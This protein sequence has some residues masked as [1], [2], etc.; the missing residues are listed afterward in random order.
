MLWGIGRGEHLMLREIEPLVD[1]PVGQN[2]Q[3]HPTAGGSW[4]TS[5]PVSLLVA[6]LPDSM[7]QH[8]EDFMQNG[9]G[10]L[11]SN[12]GESGGFLRTSAVPPAP[13]MQ[14]H[15]RPGVF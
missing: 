1:L 15:A 3:D 13:G 10:P 12:I 6:V 4:T 2:L 7:H 11:T 5:L 9:H 8:L 14:L